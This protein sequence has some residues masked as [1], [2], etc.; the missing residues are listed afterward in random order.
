M[1]QHHRH[2]YCP[3]RTR[4][5]APWTWPCG[6]LSSHLA[7]AGTSQLAGWTATACK[8]SLMLPTPSQNPPI[9][10]TYLITK[11]RK[12]KQNY[13]LRRTK[14]EY[15]SVV[16]HGKS[17]IELMPISNTLHRTNIKYWI[18]DFRIIRQCGPLKRGGVYRVTDNIWDAQRSRNMLKMTAHS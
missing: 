13:D 16:A 10:M 4:S 17:V 18:T 3:N 15:Y 5:H 12:V 6:I 11:V 14:N 2:H 1:N 9:R 7:N 8:F